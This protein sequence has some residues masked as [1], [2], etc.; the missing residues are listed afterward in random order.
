MAE[1]PRIERTIEHVVSLRRAGAALADPRESR[2]LKRVER[3]LQRAIGVGVPKRRA[4]A[5]LG[6]SVTALDKWIARGRLPV[7]RR[8]G[9]SREQIDADALLDLAEEVT[10][11]RED[12]QTRALLAGAFERLAQEGRPRPKLRPNQPAPELREHYRRTTPSDRLREVAELSRVL[13]DLA[14]RGANS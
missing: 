11:L 2:R 12:G 4:A 7:V 6:V 3:E 1:A 13:T 5:V 10:R 9:S 14:A 8:P